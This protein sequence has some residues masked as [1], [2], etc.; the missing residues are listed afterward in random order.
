LTAFLNFLE[1]HKAFM[2]YS[3]Q[4]NNAKQM[5]S[6]KLTQ[7]SYPPCVVVLDAMGNCS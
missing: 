3:A 2:K 1:S 6:K 7:L 5:A 4:G